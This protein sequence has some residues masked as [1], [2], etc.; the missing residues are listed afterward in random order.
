MDHDEQEGAADRFRSV[1][2]PADDAIDA[3]DEWD[4]APY[5]STPRPHKRRGYNSAKL[6]HS[7]SQHRRR[8]LRRHSSGGSDVHAAAH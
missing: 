3:N 6:L 4:E 5:F 1:S 2:P 8:V 7:P